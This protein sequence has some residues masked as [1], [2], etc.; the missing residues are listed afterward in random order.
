[1]ETLKLLIELELFYGFGENYRNYEK[2]N[3][4]IFDF[5]AD[6]VIGFEFRTKE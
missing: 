2:P 3:L 5:F 6:G 4:Y 1:M